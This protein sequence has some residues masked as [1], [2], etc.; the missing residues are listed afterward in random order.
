MQG[1]QSTL[2]D[3][4]AQN[5]WNPQS[6]LFN[7]TGGT[8]PMASA[9]YRLA[10]ELGSSFV[11]L[12]SQGGRSLLYRYDYDQSRGY[13]R[14]RQDTEQDSE[15]PEVI[16]IDDYFK[17]H[18]IWNMKP[19]GKKPIERVIAEALTGE[20]SEVR[21]NVV[22]G[23]NMEIDLVVRQKNQVGI[24]EIKCGEREKQ[25]PH[26]KRAI[27][28]LTATEQRYLGTYTK[29]LLILDRPLDANNEDLAKAHR[30]Q[31]IVLPSAKSK[32]LSQEGRDTLVSEVKQSLGA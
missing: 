32:C 5:R 26:Q 6:L 1:I 16:T 17:A 12:Q 10:E 31:V 30:I 24:A 27:E 11:Y 4:I 25:S 21:A 3:Q 15:I 28:Q 29:K 2:G 20:F 8:K 14:R 13:Q 19:A 7:L 9:A 18:G 22:F 23:G